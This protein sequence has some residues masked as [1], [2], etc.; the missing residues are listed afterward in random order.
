MT[1]TNGV[2]NAGL[3]PALKRADGLWATRHGD[4]PAGQPYLEHL[5]RYLTPHMGPS[6]GDGPPSDIDAGEVADLRARLA[7][8]ERDLATRTA[9]ADQLAAELETA[10]AALERAGADLKSTEAELEMVRDERAHLVD[11]LGEARTRRGHD[12][13]AVGNVLDELKKLKSANAVLRQKLRRANERADEVGKHVHRYPAP[14]PG[15]PLEP[16]E[17][18]RPYPRYFEDVDED[19]DGA[20][21]VE[22]WA[23]LFDRI[24]DEIAE[25]PGA[26]E[27]AVGAG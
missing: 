2:D 16:C 12:E 25:W 13:Q 4:D 7:T 3:L 20:P 5:E 22:P 11:D 19:E 9:A 6:N 24:R 26:T 27:V 21:D 15:L 17:C 18:G 8:A 1:K 10:R 14:G 23:D